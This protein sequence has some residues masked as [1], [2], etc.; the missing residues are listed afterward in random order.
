MLGKMSFKIDLKIFFFLVIFYFTKQISTYSYM[1]I[2]AILHE[3]GHL[4]MGIV[5]GFKPESISFAPLGFAIKFRIMED[6]YNNKV[7]KSNM[8][9]IKKM[10]IAMAGPAT[11]II[12]IF[13]FGF[14]NLDFLDKEMIIYSNL[15][16][17]I[18]NLMPI[19][20]LDGGRILKSLLNL[21]IGRKKAYTYIQVITNVFMV[22]LTFGG[23][24]LVYY[25]KNI[26]V[27]LIVVYLWGIVVKENKFIRLKMK[28]YENFEKNIYI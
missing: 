16:I 19:Y 23:S 9:Q 14:S 26:A 28:L 7:C 2:F 27:F 12:L 21:L 11:N 10:L 15:L 6:E 22:L 8:V 24:I 20:P 18:F 17:A 4:F 1:M 25:F 3:L 13:L 5:V